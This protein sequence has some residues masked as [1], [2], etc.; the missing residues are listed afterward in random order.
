MAEGDN[1]GSVDGVV[2]FDPE[3]F[4][5]LKPQFADLSD[6]VLQFAFEAAEIY[7]KG[8]I[9]EN[10]ATSPISYRDRKAILYALTCHFLTLDQLAATTSGL[11]MTPSSVSEGSVSV[12]LSAMT[13]STT[14]RP[15]GDLDQTV[16][17]KYAAA[18][19]R[20]L[21]GRESPR[22]IIARDRACVRWRFRP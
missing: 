7:L 14:E 19:M 2:V 8:T 3:L 4:R 12:G 5:Q 10:V 6:Q 18:L 11:A 17:G 9:F 20:K 21:R 16:C 1:P 22:L 15:I 13:V